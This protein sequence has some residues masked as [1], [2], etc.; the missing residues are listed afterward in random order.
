MTHGKTN[1]GLNGLRSLL[2][3]P[4]SSCHAILHLNR[5]TP[6]HF[7][8]A[9]VGG[10]RSVKKAKAGGQKDTHLIRKLMFQFDV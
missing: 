6:R 8:E 4:G 10:L 3:E 2:S 9:D 1:M 7:D 5:K